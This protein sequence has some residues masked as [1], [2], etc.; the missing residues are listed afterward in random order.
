M[1][2]E[3]K[4]ESDK[5]ISKD[6]AIGAGLII[7]LPIVIII[8]LLTLV[9][10]T[11]N[12][13]II[14]HSIGILVSVGFLFLM[15]FL[16]VFGMYYINGRGCHEETVIIDSKIV[17]VKYVMGKKDWDK[18]T[19]KFLDVSF[20]N[21]KNYL[22]DVDKHLDLT[23]SSKLILGLHRDLRYDKVLSEGWEIDNIIKVPE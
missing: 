7:L 4:T 5:K 15:L 3:I 20:S 21:G 11:E 6:K 1:S 16:G 13:I 12:N 8:G 19:I 10:I 22:I 18:D 9:Y 17:S 2:E 14:N 23:V